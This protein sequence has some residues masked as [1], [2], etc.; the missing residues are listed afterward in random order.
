MTST[1]AYF[2]ECSTRKKNKKIPT[3]P[4]WEEHGMIENHLTLLSL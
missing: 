4:T 2:D 3:N 1:E